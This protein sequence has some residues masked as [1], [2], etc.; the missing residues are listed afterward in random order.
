MAKRFLLLKEDKVTESGQTYSKV[1]DSETLEGVFA[2]FHMK[3]GHA[4][5][6]MI[7]EVLEQSEFRMVRKH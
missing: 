1:G 7:L 2:Q 3:G 6:M 5:G 4:N